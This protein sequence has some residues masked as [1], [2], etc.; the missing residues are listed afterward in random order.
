MVVSL[1]VNADRE[2]VVSAL[3][4]RGLTVAFVA[5]DAD[6]AR[7]VLAPHSAAVVAAEI[8]QIPGV[9]SVAAPVSSHPRIDAQ[10]PAVDVRGLRVSSDSPVAMCGPCS[11]ESEQQIFA[12]AQGLAA[13]GVQFLRGGAF[14]PRTSPYSFEGHGAPALTWLRQAADAHGLRTVTEVLSEAEVEIVAAHADLLQ[15]GSRNMQNFALLQAVAR[16]GKPVLL[17]R[18]MSATVEEWLLAAERLLLH[19]AAGVILCERGIR[20]FDPMTRN[21]LDLGAVAL[22]SQ[23]HRLPVVVDPSHAV[24]RRDLVPTLARAALAAGAAG[25]MIETHDDPGSA[26]SDGAQAIPLSEMGDLMPSL[27]APRSAPQLHG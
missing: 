3:T 6:G 14:K 18:G 5:A 7:I 8:M 17:K 15:V 4:A 20:S 13:L 21:L 12:I 22:L 26:L 25:V 11:V 2:S 16:A 23:V 1:F 27:L 9:R 24:G 10:G 19:G